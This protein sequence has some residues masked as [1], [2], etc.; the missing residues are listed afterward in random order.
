MHECVLLCMLVRTYE[1]MIH[2]NVN[3]SYIHFS[4]VGYDKFNFQTTLTHYMLV[5]KRLYIYFTVYGCLAI[6]G[7]YNTVFI[8]KLVTCLSKTMHII[9]NVMWRI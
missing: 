2:M 9:V 5:Y 3:N 7:S 4:S 8:L 6:R 1:C